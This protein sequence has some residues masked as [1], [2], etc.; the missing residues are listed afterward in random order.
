VAK[1]EASGTIKCPHC[2]QPVPE[3]SHF[4]LFC[5]ARVSSPARAARG[6]S[7]LTLGLL[8]ILIG[9]GLAAWGFVS[10][11]GGGGDKA[12]NVT[13]L[14]RTGLGADG[15]DLA[16]DQGDA[17]TDMITPGDETQSGSEGGDEPDDGGSPP[18]TGVASPAQ[19]LAAAFGLGEGETA[20]PCS[21]AGLGDI[22]CYLLYLTNLEQGCYLYQVGLPFSEPFAWALVEQQGDGTFATTETAD[23]DFEEVAT[24]P[25]SP[26]G[27]MASVTFTSELL[28]DHPTDRLDDDSNPL[29]AGATEVFVFVR[30]TGLQA[31]DE[32]TIT[33]DWDSSPIGEPSTIDIDPSGEGCATLRIAQD[34]GTEL[35]VGMST[36][37]V[38]LN[39]TAIAR[40]SLSV[41]P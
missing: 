2:R 25:F 18:A 30:Y 12:G 14:A 37:T 11:S 38:L 15:H 9:V 16:P 6:R 28:D 17:A 29:P 21:T 41:L 32:A 7:L 34:D 40:G 31:S 8:A 10:A 5:G 26:G 36:V 19:A 20:V 24:P 1:A 33:L 39:G 22:L 13:P 35:P 3:S 27:A 4:C 23:F